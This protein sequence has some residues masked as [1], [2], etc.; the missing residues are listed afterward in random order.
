M[1]AVIYTNF[2]ASF[3]KIGMDKISC[4]PWFEKVTAHKKS[5]IFKNKHRKGGK[6]KAKD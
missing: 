4:N 5:Q 1:F 3:G 6:T 2:S